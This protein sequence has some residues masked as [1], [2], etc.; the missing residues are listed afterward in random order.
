M[1][2]VD[3][4]KKITS[5]LRERCQTSEVESNGESF[6]KQN[7][8]RSQHVGQVISERFDIVPKKLTSLASAI[9][10][11]SEIA[12]LCRPVCKKVAR[13][14]PVIAS[15]TSLLISGLLAWRQGCHQRVR[16]VKA[17]GVPPCMTE[18]LYRYREMIKIK[19]V[20]QINII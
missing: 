19:K 12:P 18:I 14:F 2:L 17:N 16:V 20:A 5:C 8:C 10:I 11:Y 3:G 13:L 7:I 1:W 9:R 6:H 4:K 15:W